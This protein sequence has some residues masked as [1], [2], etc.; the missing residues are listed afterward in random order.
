MSSW[1][2]LPC[3]TRCWSG[4]RTARPGR[5]VARWARSERAVR[6]SG[7]G[8][9]ASAASRSENT[10]RSGSDPNHCD[11]GTDRLPPAASMHQNQTTLRH[12]LSQGS[13]RLDM[14][15]VRMIWVQIP[16]YLLVQSRMCTRKPC[17][18]AAEAEPGLSSAS[19]GSAVLS[20]R[21]DRW[22]QY[23]KGKFW[24]R[25]CPMNPPPSPS[26]VSYLSP[27]CSVLLNASE[28]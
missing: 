5:T 8:R 15:S 14:V 24:I 20:A 21:L 7:A 4:S 27:I 3:W 23:S 10:S 28:P 26:L 12:G 9:G 25:I 2:F 6:R 13:Y 16:L 1:C 17:N 19:R 18:G 22:T 11:T